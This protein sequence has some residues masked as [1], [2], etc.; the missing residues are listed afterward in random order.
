ME[1]KKLN[2]GYQLRFEDFQKATGCQRE[3]RNEFD[4][5]KNALQPEVLS[6][7]EQDSYDLLSIESDEDEIV[8]E[9]QEMG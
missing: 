6:D 7:Y 1:D 4:M 8:H 5:I 2:P 9:L 3:D